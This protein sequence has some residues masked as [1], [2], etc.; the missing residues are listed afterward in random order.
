MIAPEAKAAKIEKVA[1]ILREELNVKTV[2]VGTDRS[3]LQS[4]T[5]IPVASILGRK[6]GREFTK[7]GA[8]IKELGPLD[9]ATL[10][11]GES[12]N[13]TVDNKPVEVLPEE[14]D[15]KSV[16]HDDYS[17]VEEQDMLVGVYTV[18]SEELRGEGLARDVVRRIQSLR[19]DADFEIDDQITTYYAGSSEVELVFEGE[20]EYIKLE[21][22]SDELVKGDAPDGAAVQEFEIDGLSLKLGLVKK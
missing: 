2:T 13:M 4:L 6:Y 18:I 15:L 8:A 5:V 16:P 20:S 21:T 9:A 19:K 1:D 12:V 10:A 17:V 11:A 7:I 3:A 14:V 22:L